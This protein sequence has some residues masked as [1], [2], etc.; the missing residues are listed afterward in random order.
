MSS[1][2]SLGYWVFFIVINIVVSA[3]T[4]WLVVR[5]LVP[6]P[7]VAA[8]VTAPKAAEQAASTPVS[9]TGMPV[10][11]PSNNGANANNDTAVNTSPTPEA[12]QNAAAAPDAQAAQPA[13]TQ[14]TTT[15]D[16]PGSNSANVRITAVIYPGQQS[17]EVIVIV[18]EGD[19]IN[20]NG[21]TINTPRGKIFTFGNLTLY[22]E[23]FIN[24]HTTNGDNTA[25]DLFWNQ[26]EPVW[27]SGDNV[28][29]KNST[30]VVATYTVK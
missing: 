26:T 5:Q 28:E 13:S 4:T 19:D 25:T 21:W 23:S 7:S 16:N 6:S 3:L 30:T 22:K 2:P 11:A 1:R 29:L 14:V 12:P 8:S 24:V 27:Q 10:A 18:N 20:L 9:T 15:L 17:R